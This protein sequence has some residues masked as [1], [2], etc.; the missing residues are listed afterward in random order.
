MPSCLICSRAFLS[1]PMPI[2]PYKTT[3]WAVVAPLWHAMTTRRGGMR[4]TRRSALAPREGR[5]SAG[6]RAENSAGIRHQ[7]P[8]GIDGA[9]WYVAVDCFRNYQ[10]WREHCMCLRIARRAL[11][12]QARF[13]LHIVRS[14]NTC[15]LPDV[16]AWRVSCEGWLSVPGACR[17]QHATAHYLQWQ[18]ARI[19]PWK[20]SSTYHC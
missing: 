8:P 18:A 6:A 2:I 14:Y 10:V 9:S 5:A 3:L 7:L 12:Q 11:R 17:R 13:R 19:K 4:T 20:I 15:T 1:Q 16:A